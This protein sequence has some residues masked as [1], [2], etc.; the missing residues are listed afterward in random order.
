MLYILSLKVV[1]AYYG[2]KFEASMLCQIPNYT[3][4][5]HPLNMGLLII[6]DLQCNWLTALTC[7]L[8]SYLGGS[9]AEQLGSS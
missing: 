7:M 6:I 3:Y 8:L 5:F 9:S 2:L 4:K 1:S